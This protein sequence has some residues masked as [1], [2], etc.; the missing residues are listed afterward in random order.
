[1]LFMTQY[2]VYTGDRPAEDTTS[3][4]RRR[5]VTDEDKFVETSVVVDDEMYGTY[6]DSTENYVLSILNQVG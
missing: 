4:R 5:D 3:K 2:L 1:M 6:G